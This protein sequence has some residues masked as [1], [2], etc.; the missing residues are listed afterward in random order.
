MKKR[1]LSLLLAML[2][3]MTLVPT[4]ALADRSETDIAYAV[5]GGNIYLNKSTGEITG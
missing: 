4:A 5:T 1:I 2:M 3:V